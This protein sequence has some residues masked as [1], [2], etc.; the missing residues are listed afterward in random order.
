[1]STIHIGRLVERLVEEKPMKKN[2]FAKAMNYSPTNISS[3]FA[4]ED[5]HVGMVEQAGRVLDTNIMAMLVKLPEAGSIVMEDSPAYIVGKQSEE[6]QK[7]KKQLA[8]S[9]EMISILIDQ[10]KYLKNK[11]KQYESGEGDY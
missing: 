3:L 11:L 7:Y 6:L 2:V 4:R 8:E 1:M 5:W 9:K 10:N